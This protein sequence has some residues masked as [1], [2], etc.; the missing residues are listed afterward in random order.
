MMPGGRGRGIGLPSSLDP[1]EPTAMRLILVGASGLVGRH[2]LEFA[3]H[4]PRVTHVIAPTRRPL[5]D[6]PK[7]VAPRVNFDRLPD[8]SAWWRADAVICTLGTTMRAAGS[9][10]AFRIVDHHYPRAV[11]HLAKR[12]GTPVYAL[13]S[14]MGA[15]A[16]SR[17]FYNRVKGEL[18]R[19][20]TAVG[21]RS[22]TLVRP[23]LIG[24]ER[25]ER[26]TGEHFATLLLRT[27]DP[28]LPPRW[29]INPAPAIARALLDAVYAGRDGVHVVEAASLHR[30]TS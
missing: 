14:A 16:D 18:E 1:Q 13:N 9:R 3:L 17:V 11:A 7:L 29:R 23:G 24:G 5:V 22:L 28:L 27:L 19:D 4:D 2:V 10:A 20:L 12:H 6:H 30:A 21:F 8:D 25:D 15:D 26:R